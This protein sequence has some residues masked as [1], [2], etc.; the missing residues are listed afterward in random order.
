MATPKNKPLLV[1]KEICGKEATYR[2]ALITKQG[3]NITVKIGKDKFSAKTVKGAMYLIDIYFNV[4][5]RQGK[6]NQH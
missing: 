1:W 2:T 5:L 3:T 4:R 6:G